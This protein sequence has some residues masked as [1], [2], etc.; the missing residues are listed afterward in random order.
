MFC[1]FERFV[2]CQ[3][4]GEDKHRLMH[5]FRGD[6]GRSH[7]VVARRTAFS[8]FFSSQ[9]W[10]VEFEDNEIVNYGVC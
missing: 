5:Q 7:L 2:L 4:V 6:G 3:I 8:F 1:D 9:K 10:D